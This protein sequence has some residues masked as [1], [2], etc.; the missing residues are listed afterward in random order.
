MTEIQIPTVPP[1]QNQV[2]DPQQQ[3]INVYNTT[4]NAKVYNITI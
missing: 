3:T 2:C 4:K 1:T